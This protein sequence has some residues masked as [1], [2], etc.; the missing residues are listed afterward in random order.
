MT[1]TTNTDQLHSAN[2]VNKV[3]LSEVEKTAIETLS[4]E[5]I[6]HLISIDSKLKESDVTVGLIL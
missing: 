2:V 5:E 1:D 4:Q 3:N 6:S